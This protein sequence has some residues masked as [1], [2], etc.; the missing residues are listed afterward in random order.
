[1]LIMD[2][3]VTDEYVG[4]DSPTYMSQSCK[5]ISMKTHSDTPIP[6]HDISRNKL[7]EIPQATTRMLKCNEMTNNS[8]F[9]G[10]G[11]LIPVSYKCK[12]PPIRYSI[13]LGIT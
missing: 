6:D 4:F 2:K 5:I 9:Q 12:T 1:M 13:D 3:C 8:G 7:P 10:R 11:S